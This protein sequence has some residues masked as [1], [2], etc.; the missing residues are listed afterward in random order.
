MG[1][2]WQDLWYGARMLRKNPGFTAIAILTIALGIGA[3]TA[4]FSIVDWVLL[5][6]LPVSHPERMTYLTIQQ[7]GRNTNGFSFPD[8]ADIQKQTT[9]SFSDVAAFDLGQDGLT[10][11]GKTQPIFTAYISGNFFQMLGIHPA[12]GRFIL[13][14]EG[15]VAGADP[16]VVL[17]YSTWVTRFGSDPSAIGKSVAVNGRHMTI[18]GVAPQ[19]FQGISAGLDF[20]GYLPI[21]MQTQTLDGSRPADYMTNRESRSMLI[22]ARL[23]DGV[24]LDQARS[25]LDVVS[26]RLA[27][28]YPK[29]NEDM[30]FHVWR[31]TPA[32]PNSNPENSPIGTLGALFLGLAFLV[33]VLACLNVANMLLVRAAARGREMAVRAALGAAR[34]RLIR[35][36]LAESLLLAGLGC[37]AGI[38]VGLMASQAMSSV[39]VGA[40]IPIVMNFQFDW[41]VFAFAFGI[42]LLTGILAGIV[43]ALRASRTDLSTMLH[44]GERSMTRSRQRMR[45]ALVVAQVAGSLALLVVA[46]L[47]TRSLGNVH[48]S[49]LGFDP[50]HVM[51]FTMDPRGIGFSQAQSTEFYQQLLDRI[52]AVPGVQSAALAATVPMGEVELGGHIEI[53][54]RPVANGQPPN[55]ASDN[56][57]TPQYF[58]VMRIPLLRGRGITDGDKQNSQR[59]AVVNETMA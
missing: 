14:T 11:D 50:Q 3:N 49:D 33:L 15:A 8:F 19:G 4:I 54:G 52:S 40:T 16:V 9:S 37:V 34:G 17:S 24:S 7:K 44:D 20:Q 35:Q 10:V 18:V 27:K 58:D 25:E 39:N 21:S 30:A 28:E 55:S 26:Q 46:G 59:I 48:M 13:P 47:F 2:L 1:S 38:G 23:K 12:A 45:S 29:T 51:N 41:R 36:L 32:G 5:R 56:F 53:E 57:V 42:A 31:L 6:P 22:L 43:P